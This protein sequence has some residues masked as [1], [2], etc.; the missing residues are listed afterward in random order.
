MRLFTIGF[1]QSSAAHFFG[2]LKEAGVTRLIDVRLNRR[3]QLAGF[4]KEGD[5]AWFARELC[6]IETEHALALAPTPALLGAYRAGEVDWPEYAARF[7]RLIARRRIETQLDRAR[8]DGAC[9]LCSE[10]LP[11]HCHRRVVA[12]YLRETWGKVEVVDL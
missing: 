9:L 11:H 12:E 3:S 4:A 6:G 1:T 10:A 2:R 7:K 8:L 5:L